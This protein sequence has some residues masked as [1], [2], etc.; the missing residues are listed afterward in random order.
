MVCV[1][2][3][4][5]RRRP[6]FWDDRQRTLLRSAEFDAVDHTRL[7]HRRHQ[8]PAP[9]A[10]HIPG[11]TLRRQVGPPCPSP[12]SYLPRALVLITPI[13]PSVVGHRIQRGVNEPPAFHETAAHREQATTPRTGCPRPADPTASAPTYPAIMTAI[14]PVARP[15]PQGR[16]GT[17]LGT[18]HEE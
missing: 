10:G 13:A 5:S 1:T 12:T 4:G 6:R 9:P 3:S 15:A 16:S 17:P 2:S 11:R 14:S 8:L 18:G 7:G